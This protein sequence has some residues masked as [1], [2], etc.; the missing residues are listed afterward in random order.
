ME[1]RVH[2]ALLNAACRTLREATARLHVIHD[3]DVRVATL[4]AAADV[5]AVQLMNR[6]DAIVIDIRDAAEYASGHVLNARNLPVAELEARIGEL[7]AWLGGE[8]GRLCAVNVWSY[9]DWM[10]RPRTPQELDL[11]T[12]GG[13]VYR[14]GPH[15]VDTVRTLV[16]Q[17]QQRGVSVV[18]PVDVVVA[19][20]FA[21]DAA[22]LAAAVFALHPR[23]VVPHLALAR[24]AYRCQDRRPESE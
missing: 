2:R 6:Q 11:R 5:E 22:A 3:L 9:T 15:Q 8:L 4:Q 23:V 14:Q 17:A 13:I 20:A 10:F 24:E 12:G 1:P 16:M 19:D 21:A 7:A 18:V